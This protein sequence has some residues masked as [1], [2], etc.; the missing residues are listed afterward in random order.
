VSAPDVAVVGGGIVGC[1]L[2]AL[3][4]EGGA[5]VRL[6]EREAIAA[7][8]SG[9]NSGVLQHPLDEALVPLHEASLE[10]YRTLDHGFELPAE[11]VGVLLLSD[12]GPALEADRTEVAARFPELA[13]EW[14]E[15]AA[16]EAAEPG[17]GPGL[18]AYRQ[19]TGRPVPPAAAARAWARRAQEAGAELR[20]GAAVEALDRRGGRV[21]GVTVG[22]R[23]EPAGEVV[24]AAGPWTPELIAPDG[25]WRPIAPSWGVNVEVRLAEPPRHV[26][27]Q[28]GVEQIARPDGG[29][30]SIFSIVT[31][32]GVSAVGSTFLAEEPDAPAHAPRLL[33]RGA[34]YLPA[35][36][37][38]DGFAARACPRPQS[39][40]GRPLLGAVEAGLHVAGGHGPWGISLGPGSA[41]LVA[42]ALLGRAGAIAPELAAS[43]FGR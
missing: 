3:L 13:P 9:R 34:R 2:A 39:R 19:A 38:L 4:A 40:D 17:L 21:A 37:R 20:V 22:G 41:R 30:D 6:Y 12:D 35:L 16:L 32:A 23:P 25:S 1:A 7:A 11:P 15:G 31:A 26:L 8:A 14:L 36:A 27:E 10:L 42:D 29:V 33:E 28:A 18:F 5:G 24:V 43:R